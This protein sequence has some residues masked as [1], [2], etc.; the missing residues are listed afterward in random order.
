MGYFRACR[1]FSKASA[2]VISVNS[3]RAAWSLIWPLRSM[4]AHG[5]AFGLD[6]GEPEL[7]FQPTGFA[8][9]GARFI[10]FVG[11]GNAAPVD[12]DNATAPEQRKRPP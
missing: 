9:F 10:G 8:C 7:Q 11:G 2:S 4:G 6:A 3:A 5:S 1:P 12:G